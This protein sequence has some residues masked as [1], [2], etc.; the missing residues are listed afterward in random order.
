MRKRLAY[1]AAI[2]LALTAA[3]TT[4]AATDDPTYL[5]QLEKWRAERAAGLT[6]PDSWLSV[7]GLEWLKP[8]DNVFGSS[9]D[10][11]LRIHAPGSA[12][13]GVL[14]LDQDAVR[15][16]A[17]K[18][19]F[20]PGLA[21]DE[22]PATEQAVVVKGRTPTQ[23]TYG[24]YSFFVIQRG[25]KFAL[26]IKNSRAAALV[27]FHHL[28]WYVPKPQYRVEADW[29][30]FPEPKHETVDDVVGIK[31]DGLAFGVAKFKLDGHDVELEPVVDNER[32]KTLMF[33]LRDA[34]SGKTT[35]GASRFLYTDLPDHGFRQPGK[36][37]LDFNRLQNPPCAYTDFATC[38][39]PIQANRLK[40]AIPAGELN[41]SHP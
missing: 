22:H 5:Q 21:I 1:S 18:S 24:T 28:N 33:V 4:Y 34:T 2:L 27:N 40:V 10:S 31:S 12:Q 30:P 29:V 35:Y 37:L 25:D 41:Y 11:Q 23:F 39:L 32:A 20:A 15:L 3:T 6:A 36:L 38:P 8:G 14:A 19:G 16:K 26:R 13:F 7:V 9:P 17:P